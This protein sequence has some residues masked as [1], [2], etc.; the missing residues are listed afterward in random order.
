M[1]VEGWLFG[2]ERA[3]GTGGSGLRTSSH[4]RATDHRVVQLPQT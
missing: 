2:I 1:A 3:V 4:W